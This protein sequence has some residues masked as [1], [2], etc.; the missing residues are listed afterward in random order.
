MNT[1]TR[2]FRTVAI[3]EAITWTGLLLGMFLKYGPAENETGVRIFGMLHGIVFVAYVVTTVVVWVDRRWSAGRGLLALVA[4]V[5]PL[6]TLPL[7]WFA[8]RKGWLGDAWR[9]PAGASSSF[10]DRVVAWLLTNPLR[11]LGVGLVA[12]AALTGVA[13][14]VGPP[15]S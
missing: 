9:L 15:G 10:P 13:L 14:V 8:I 2:L 4:A 5:P 12:V 7:E 6:A 3:A 1:P 11:G